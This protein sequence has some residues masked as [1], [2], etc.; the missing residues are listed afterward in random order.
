MLWISQR[1]LILVQALKEGAL[2]QELF[3]HREAA[4]VPGKGSFEGECLGEGEALQIQLSSK[5]G[6]FPFCS[7][8]TLIVII[9]L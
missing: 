8:F 5:P 1:N 4:E 9:S 2:G 6:N 7:C 3:K